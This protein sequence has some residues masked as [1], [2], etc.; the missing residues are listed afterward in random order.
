[1]ELA[2]VGL[3]SALEARGISRRQFLEFCG[4]M[5]AT[6]ALPSKYS[7]AIAQALEKTK[8]PVLVWLEFQDC[9]GNSESMLRSGDPPIGDFVLEML[10]WEYHEL[11]MAGAGKKAE[12]TLQ[13]IVRD[14]KGE[15]I[16]VVEGAIPTADGGIYCT[17]GGRTALDIAREV[18]TNAAANIAIGACAWDGG[19]VAAGSNPT[20][21]VGLRKLYLA[22]RSSTLADARTILPTQ[23]LC[24]FTI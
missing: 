5:T 4:L 7:T 24:S 1:M 2:K 21:A 14:H 13:R 3:R 23:P 10:S 11:I 9:A 15:Y 17:I 19:I 8:K 20:G 18:C 16:V 12:E 6:L 22:S